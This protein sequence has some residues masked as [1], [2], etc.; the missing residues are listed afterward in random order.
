MNKG[1]I[2]SDVHRWCKHRVKKCSVC[3]R[4]FKYQHTYDSHVCEDV[5]KPKVKVKIK[6]KTERK[7][8]EM[9]TQQ[10]VEMVHQL[11]GEIQEMRNQPTVQIN[12]LTVITDDIFSRIAKEM[13]QDQA[14]KFLLDSLTSKEECLSIVDKV[15]LSGKDKN[16]YPI[17]CKN[18]D[19]FRFLGPNSKVVDDVGG[20]QIVS[21]I[22]DSVQNAYLKANQSLLEGHVNATGMKELYSMYDLKLM[23]EKIIS[24]PSD[25]RKQRLREELAS[26]VTNPTHPFFQLEE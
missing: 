24:L 6:V 3:N 22:T 23:Q 12:N 15:Y 21:K 16:Q 19:H 5:S 14:V 7:E 4:S 26:K 8:D 1:K 20:H 2:C 25:D 18:K 17:A 9:D 10:L 13:G 11:R